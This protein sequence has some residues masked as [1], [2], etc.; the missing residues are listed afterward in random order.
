MSKPVR[1]YVVRNTVFFT[2]ET[3]TFLNRAHTKSSPLLGD[4]HRG[5]I[6]KAGLVAFFQSV[7]QRFHS[8]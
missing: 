3:Q 1:M 5:L 4:K 8:L 7:L 6:K 2:P